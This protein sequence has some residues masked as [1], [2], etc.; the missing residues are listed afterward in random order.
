MS[1]RKRG[2]FE[3]ILDTISAINSEKSNTRIMYKANLSWNALKALCTRLEVLGLVESKSI[4]DRPGISRY[5]LTE[6]GEEVLK[7]Y[8]ELLAILEM[9][10][11]VL[12]LDRCRTFDRK[13]YKKHVIV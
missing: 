2:L 8:Q 10:E 5:V 13:G 7:I 6:S 11:I 1:R 9:E 3:L 4:V 12:Y